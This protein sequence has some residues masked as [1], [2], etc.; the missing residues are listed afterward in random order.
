MQIKKLHHVGIVVE[1]LQRAIDKFIGFGF[2]CTEVRDLKEVGITIAF[3]P[4]GDSLIELLYYDPD[5]KQEAPAGSQGGALN[6][7]CFEVADLESSIQLFQKNG[8]KLTEGFPKA[9][10]KGR[11]AFFD[12]ETTEGILMEILQE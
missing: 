12:P 7:I 5:K 3:F 10:G 1:N 4:V 2:S 11:I 9:M 8:A 6:H